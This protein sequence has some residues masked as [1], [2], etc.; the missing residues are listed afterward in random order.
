MFDELIN[1]YLLEKNVVKRE[2]K[3]RK[4]QWSFLWFG[5]TGV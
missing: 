1:F 5:E 3:G 4:V 2:K